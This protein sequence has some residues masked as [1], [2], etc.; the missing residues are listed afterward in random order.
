MSAG[1]E[2]REGTEGVPKEDERDK[3]NTEGRER[4]RVSLPRSSVGVDSPG[5][6][7]RKHKGE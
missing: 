1:G 4:G 7:I 6:T 5:N 2:G 3:E